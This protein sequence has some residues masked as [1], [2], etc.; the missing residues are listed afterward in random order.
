MKYF[1]SDKFRFL[2]SITATK[3]AACHEL[4]MWDFDFSISITT[5]GAA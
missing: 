1:V 3:G 2:Y 5:K 4:Y